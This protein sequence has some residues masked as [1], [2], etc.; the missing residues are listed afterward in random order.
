MLYSV[1]KSMCEALYDVNWDSIIRKV[2]TKC[3]KYIEQASKELENRDTGVFLHGKQ[4]YLYKMGDDITF[5]VRGSILT[6][7]IKIDKSILDKL[8]IYFLSSENTETKS[9]NGDFGIDEEGNLSITIYNVKFDLKYHYAHYSK[10]TFRHEF[11]HFLDYVRHGKLRP[12]SILSSDD[13]IDL[14]FTE[15]L[16][17]PNEYLAHIGADVSDFF[18]AINNMDKIRTMSFEDFK[19][20]LNTLSF[21]IFK[22]NPKYQ[23]KANKSLY[24][25]YVDL[26]ENI[27]AYKLIT[28]MSTSNEPAA[29]SPSVYLKGYEALERTKNPDLKKWYDDNYSE[30]RDWIETVLDSNNYREFYEN[31]YN[32]PEEVKYLDELRE[33]F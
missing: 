1:Y 30:L 2:E 14:W 7:I 6:D 33:L 9:S 17:S 12:N 4:V 29:I 11:I 15:Y 19:K 24:K 10:N 18:D 31:V 22:M 20:K 27:D 25:I 8:T 26:K 23:K 32:K 5:A 16:S 13:D 28:R 21:K 3:L